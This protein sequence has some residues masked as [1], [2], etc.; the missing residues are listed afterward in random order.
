MNR[1][2]MIFGAAAALTMLGT[3]GAWAAAD[4]GVKPIA[5]VIAGEGAKLTGKEMELIAVNFDEF[6]TKFIDFSDCINKEFNEA[7]AKFKEIIAAYQEK[8]KKK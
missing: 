3:S 5:P 4:C 2:I 1:A 6:Q 7:T 8:N